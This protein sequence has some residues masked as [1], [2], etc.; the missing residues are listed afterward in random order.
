MDWDRYAGKEEEAQAA[1]YGRRIAA[2]PNR[3][4]NHPS[5]GSGAYAHRRI[6]AIEDFNLTTGFLQSGA[7]PGMFDPQ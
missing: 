1:G 3:S 5:T 6:I 4:I 2:R 7:S